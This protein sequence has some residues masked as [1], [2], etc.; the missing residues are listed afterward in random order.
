MS[1]GDQFREAFEM[2]VQEMGDDILVYKN[3]G[4]PSQSVKEVRGLKNSHKG[5]PK[6]VMFQ[7]L[8]DPGLAIGDVVQQKGSRDLWR[9]VELRD[10]VLSGV[11]HSLD[12]DVVNVSATAKPTSPRED[13]HTVVIHGSVHGGVQVA[14]PNAIQHNTVQVSHIENDIR[15]ISRLLAESSLPQLEKEDAA[16]ALARISDLASREKAPDMLAKV[17]EKIESLKSIALGVSS[18]PPMIVPL[19]DLLWEK[20]KNGG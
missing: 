2:M 10:D 19:L 7:F 8:A 11:F 5:R 12:A 18:L 17:A 6:D 16:L 1:V 9:V 14:S 15:Q 13:G 20:I 3:W 4:N